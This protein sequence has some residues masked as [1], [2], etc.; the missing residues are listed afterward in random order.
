MHA[1]MN[2]ITKISFYLERSVVTQK[3]CKDYVNAVTYNAP[4]LLR[5]KY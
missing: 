1:K 3:L 5:I 4:V 2:D